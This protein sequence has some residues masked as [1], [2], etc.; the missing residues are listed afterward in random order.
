[1]TDLGNQ[2]ARIAS[3]GST[4]ASV[5]EK[6][7]MKLMVLTDLALCKKII[8]SSAIT[9][10]QRMQFR[11]FVEEYNLLLPFYGEGIPVKVFESEKL[12]I[13]MARFLPN[14]VED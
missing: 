13:K 10:D 8:Y 2:L 7:V 5:Q 9:E 11:Q 1:M 4:M 3:W 14:L 6:Y 12:L